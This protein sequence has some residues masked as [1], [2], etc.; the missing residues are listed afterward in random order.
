MKDR[1]PTYAVLSRVT[2]AMR[3]GSQKVTNDDEGEGGGGP[4]PPKNDDVIYEQPLSISIGLKLSSCQYYYLYSMKPKQSIQLIKSRQSIRPQRSMWS[5][6]SRRSILS[7]WS[8][9]SKRSIW[10]KVKIAHLR[11]S[12][13]EDF[14]LS[15]QLDQM[16]C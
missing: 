4:E 15:G 6:Q 9:R 7:I 3:G 14:L 11:G 10:V 12:T 13:F 8:I 1:N 16:D 5:R 2:R